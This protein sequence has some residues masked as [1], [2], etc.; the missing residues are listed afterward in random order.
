ML[1]IK[2][3]DDAINIYQA[4]VKAK[5]EN[6]VLFYSGKISEQEWIDSVYRIMNFPSYDVTIIF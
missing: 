3:L 2:T 6:G 4:F 1:E 5:K